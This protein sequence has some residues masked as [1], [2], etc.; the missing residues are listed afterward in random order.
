MTHNY[1]A[2]LEKL[3]EYTKQYHDLFKDA[4]LRKGFDSAI[5]GILGSGST[6]VSQ[7]A[8]LAPQTSQT[9][10]SEKRIRRLIRQENQRAP[11][12]PKDFT[13]RFLELGAK[14]L[15]GQHDVRVILDGSDLRKP[16]SSKLEHLSTVR[17][18]DGDLIPGYQ[19]LNAVGISS[20]GLQALL[21]QHTYSPLEP[22]YKSDNDQVRK[23]ILKIHRALRAT[24]VLRIT[25]ILDRG[26]D[27]L[28]VI[29]LLL[30]LGDCFIIRAQHNR[31]VTSKLG[32]EHQKLFALLDK[33][34]VLGTMQLKR[35]SVEKNKSIMRLATGQVR[36]CHCFLGGRVP[37]HAVSIE[38]PRAKGDEIGWVLL[39]NLPINE[40]EQVRQIIALYASRWAIE[41]VFAWTKTALDW[42]AVQMLDLEAVRVL[43]A[44]AFICAAFIFD[45]ELSLE[46]R[47]IAFLAHLGG[48]VERKGSKPGRRVLCLGLQRF[49]AGL[50]VQHSLHR[51]LAQDPVKD[52][53]N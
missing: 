31:N 39:T 51:F 34:D 42:E 45:L 11:S 47:V 20:S 35:P 41:E 13:N 44:Y 52:T 22:E 50:L 28:K 15:A 36:A 43:V 9:K 53:V 18:L 5:I 10:Y 49:L 33:Q 25:W 29:E 27:D 46:P 17:A 7:I 6:K 30:E 38:F 1:N 23:A 32:S 37:I 2:P 16:Y 8:R 24:G 21:Y 40:L 19:T 26:F 4:R 12:N 14:K 3:D 48:W